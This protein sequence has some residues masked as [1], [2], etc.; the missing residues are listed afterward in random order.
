MTYNID[1]CVMGFSVFLVFLKPGNTA[2]L[3][4]S[5]LPEIFTHPSF[6]DYLKNDHALNVLLGDDGKIDANCEFFL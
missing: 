1:V 2:A 3:I 5:E 4:M 6:Q